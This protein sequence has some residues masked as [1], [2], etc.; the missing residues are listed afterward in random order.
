MKKTILYSLLA[1]TISTSVLTSCEDAFGSFLDKQPSNELTEEQVFGDWSLMEQFHFDTY[2][3]L[4]HGACRI[5]NSW[6]DAATDLAETSYATGGVRSTFNIGNY[7]G[8]A[9]AA[10]LTDTW[11][12]Y[13]RGIRKC[14]MIINRIESVPKSADLSNDKY[15]Q[16]KT[17]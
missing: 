10:E 11:E 7:Y 17:D 4:R 6:L 2:N 14:N 3:F 1:L 13:Y 12:H 15:L 5:N 8:S 16:D 9:G